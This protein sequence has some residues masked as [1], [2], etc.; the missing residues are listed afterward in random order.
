MKW[1][2]TKGSSAGDA[3]KAGTLSL[4]AHTIGSWSSWPKANLTA[5]D[6]GLTFIRLFLASC[7]FF[8]HSA[9]GFFRIDGGVWSGYIN[10]DKPSNTFASIFVGGFI[11]LSGFVV[12]ASRERCKTAWEFYRRRVLRI[13]P[14]FVAASLISWFVIG[15]LA[16]TSRGAY[17]S[18]LPKPQIL[19]AKLLLLAGITTPLPI[20][21]HTGYPSPLINGPLWTI[22]YE[23]ILY[24]FLALFYGLGAFK[25]WKFAAP[26][27]ALFYAGAFIHNNSFVWILPYG[28]QDFSLGI[29]FKFG[30][31]FCSGCLLYHLRNRVRYP[32]ILVVP[33]FLLAIAEPIIFGS[34]YLMPLLGVYGLLGLGFNFPTWLRGWKVDLSYGV[35]IFGWPVQLLILEK[36]KPNLTPWT[37]LFLSYS[38]TLLIAYC[39]WR[40]IESPFLKL[41]ERSLPRHNEPSASPIGEQTDAGN[42]SRVDGSRS[43]QC[44]L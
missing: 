26:A 41:K 3:P 2:N 30:T 38:V 19:I 44:V 8:V 23:E 43:V 28:V 24:I 37:F 13:F 16:A 39:S 36:L 27:L 40:W 32:A 14:G 1:F 6:N 42:S 4:A 33:S 15:P 11:A 34:Y 22:R 12:L 5:K 21:A 35:Y 9:F 18:A 29:L 20:F 7:V 10:Y 25:T 31:Y 17:F